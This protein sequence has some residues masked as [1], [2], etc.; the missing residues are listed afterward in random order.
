MSVLSGLRNLQ[1]AYLSKPRGERIIYRAIRRHQPLRI[2]ELEVGTA[3]RSQRLL[4]L[5]TSYHDEPIVYTGIDPFESRGETDGPGLSLKQ[6]HKLLTQTGARVRLLPGPPLSAMNA[7]A[8][9]LVGTDLMLISWRT[10]QLRGPGWRFVERMLYEG[11]KVFVEYEVES[12]KGPELRWRS[13]EKDELL[14]WATAPA[15]RK[16][17]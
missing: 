3:V 4:R 6:A 14:S 11:S 12:G 5:A 16:A 10:A 15:Q 9:S 8:N 17:A 2:V 7:A 13:A 1:L